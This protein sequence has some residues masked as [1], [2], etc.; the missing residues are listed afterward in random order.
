MTGQRGLY[1]NLGGLGVANFTNQ[2]DVGILPKQR[3]K[4]ARKGQAN[5]FLDLYLRGTI[6]SVFDRIFDCNDVQLGP[7]EMLERRMKRGRLARSGWPGYEHEA[8][9]SAK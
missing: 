3:P 4:N 5:L 6:H 1:S 8:I 2:D 9:G 7:D